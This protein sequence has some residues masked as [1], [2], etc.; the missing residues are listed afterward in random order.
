MS[1]FDTW[2]TKLIGVEGGYS[3]NPDDVGGATKFGITEKTAR[4]EGY[5]GQMQ[6]LTFDI[7]KA[8]YKR[9]YWDH[10]RLDDVAISSKAIAFEM[11]DTYVNT[12]I[13]GQF[14]QRLLNVLNRQQKDYPDI[15]ADGVVG[16]STL[17][18]LRS[19]LVARGAD[20]ERVLLAGLNALQGYHYVTITEQ[21]ERNESFMYGWL[22]QRV[23]K[24][25]A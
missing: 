22:L 19:F 1:A 9:R 11:G 6:D 8:I 12:G 4:E 7:A 25:A 17:A 14:L 5:S 18:A 3:N 24:E 13:S 23:V 21:R 15:A 20:G 10:L 2:V 16:P